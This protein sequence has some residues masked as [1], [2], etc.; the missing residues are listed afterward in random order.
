MDSSFSFFSIIKINIGVFFHS[1][2]NVPVYKVSRLSYFPIMSIEPANNFLG[3][4]IK[5]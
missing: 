4:S 1:E 3:Q 5:L 2:K